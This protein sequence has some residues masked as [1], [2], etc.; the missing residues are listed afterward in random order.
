MKKLILLLLILVGLVS[1]ENFEINHPDFD[2]VSGYFPYQYPVRTLVLGDYIYDNSNDNAHRF[3]I[4]VAIG[5]LYN[6]T[7]DRVFTF[8]VDESLCNNVLFASTGDTIK[9]LPSNY[10]T[11]SSPDKIIV[12]K[13]K[14]NGGV[15]VQLTDAFFNDPSTIRN[16]YVVPLR[17]VS[18]NDVDTILVGR[19]SLP[20]ADPRIASQ[21]DV[22]PKNFTMFAIKYINEYHGTYFIYGSSTVK[23]ASNNVLETTTYSANYIEQ[24]P[25][26][27]LVTTGRYQVSLTTYLR[28]SIMTGNITMLLTFNGNNCTI[29]GAPGSTLTIS[30]TGEFRS[31]AYEWGNK[32]RDGIVLNLTVTDGVNT[33][34]SNDVLVIRDRGVVMEVYEPRVY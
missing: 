21:W 5:G 9:A 22:V 3:V 14:F 33:Y 16:K 15:T 25:T 8:Q 34:N 20:N 13:G 2:Y 7:K 10:Y 31:Q 12:P 27:K 19:T 28:S 26:V 32:K 29:T 1:C 4:S 23:D 24:N 6:N 11:L 17:L 30:G 18:S